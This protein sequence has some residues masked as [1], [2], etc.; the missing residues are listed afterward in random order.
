MTPQKL[1]FYSFW[2]SEARLVIAAIALIIG[3]TPPVTVILP[4]S[5]PLIGVGLVLAWIISGAVS[6][7]LVY[8]WLG[9]GQHIFGGKKPLDLI[10][11][12]IMVLSGINLGLA[13]LIGTNIGMSITMSYIVFLITALAYLWS[14]Y[15]LYTRYEAQGRKLF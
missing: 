5:L 2:W 15:H 6:L 12:A 8:R 11:F 13:G 7:Y 4:F 1:E 9:H 3:G 14:A 10:A